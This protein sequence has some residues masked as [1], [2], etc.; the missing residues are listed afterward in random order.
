MTKKWPWNHQERGLSGLS[1]KRREVGGADAW[2]LEPEGETE[3]PE[4]VLVADEVQATFVDSHGDGHHGLKNRRSQSGVQ[5][6]EGEEIKSPKR[7]VSLFG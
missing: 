2:R 1:G 6:E 7:K 5:G 3:V 4:T